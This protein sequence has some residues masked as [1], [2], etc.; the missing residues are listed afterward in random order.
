MKTHWWGLAWQVVLKLGTTCWASA[1]QQEPWG[2]ASFWN[3][4]HH[5]H[6]QG[7][8]YNFQRRTGSQIYRQPAE[9]G[10]CRACPLQPLPGLL[11]QA[12]SC[13]KKD[14][15]SILCP[16]I[17]LSTLNQHLVVPHF[18]METAGSIKVAIRARKWAISIDI[19]DA[20]VHVPM[21]PAVRRFLRFCVNKRTYQFTCLLFRLVTSLREFTKLLRPV[22]H[23]LRLQGIGL[24]VYL[25]DW[26]ILADSP[27]VASAHA[28]LVIRVLRHLGWMINYRKSEPTQDF[29]LIGM[30]FRAQDFTVAPLLKM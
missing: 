26:L 18:E 4:S 22:V 28:Q 29:Q 25:E 6:S 13:S 15:G 2:G 1:G 3:G 11:H 8:P 17:D 14:R 7:R 12:I 30:H 21:C 24:H 9:E 20:Y 10:V 16:V 23:L 27:Q 19:R 5:L